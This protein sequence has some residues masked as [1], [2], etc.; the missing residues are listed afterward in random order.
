MIDK[1]LPALTACALLLNAAVAKAHSSSTAWLAL[2]VDDGRISGA[3]TIDLLDLALEARIDKNGD[4]RIT[5][6]ELKQSR[7]EIGAVVAR[8]ITVSQD[9]TPPCV[10]EVSGVKS[11]NTIGRASA[12][13][14]LTVPCVF[15]SS[16][17]LR[18][19]Y[20]F[21]FDRDSTHAAIFSVDGASK[22]VFSNN[23]REIVIA[24]R[25][26]GSLKSEK[27]RT[28]SRGL[29]SLAETFRI[30]LREGVWHIFIGYDHVL[31]VLTMLLSVLHPLWRTSVREAVK[32][33]TA[34]TLAHSITLFLVATGHL[35]LP[36]RVVESVIALSI[37]IAALNNMTRFLPGRAWV[38]AGGFGLIHGFGFAGALGELG[39]EGKSVLVPV[40]GFNLGVEA[41]Q[42]IIVTMILP[43]LIWSQGI[44]GFQRSLIPA[45]SCLAAITGCIWFVERMLEI[46]IF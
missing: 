3:W 28:E 37:V 22:G 46:E 26:D 18:V 30:F 35:T 12:I 36:S 32:I 29:A 11:R 43:V 44:K 6:G 33:V 31:F 9:G 40:L 45:W 38:L 39:F 41:G 23:A 19:N 42:L 25:P 10:P 4:S 34:F 27:D 7:D 15:E 13:V 1:I 16:K 14:T 17:E 21:L 5:W 2:K 8:S 20:R 24:P